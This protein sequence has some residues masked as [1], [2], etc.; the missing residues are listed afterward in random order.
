MIVLAFHKVTANDEPVSIAIT[1]FTLNAPDDMGYLKTG[2][3]DMLESRL[4][5][6]KNITVISEVIALNFM[7]KIYGYD[8][9][10]ILN[11]RIFETIKSSHRLRRYLQQ[12]PE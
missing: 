12:D 9:A 8:A 5:Q 2:I 6:D 10:Q 3:Q 4:S 1:P 7:L 11:E